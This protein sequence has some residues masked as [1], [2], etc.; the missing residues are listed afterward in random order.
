MTGSPVLGDAW[1]DVVHEWLFARAIPHYVR[2]GVDPN[3]LAYEEFNFDGTPK[4]STQRRVMV[5]FRQTY[6]LAHAALLGE[7]S[8]SIPLGLFSRM[9][10]S[11][12]H[13]DGGWVHCLDAEGHV[14]DTTREAYDQAFAM[15]A[16]AWIYELTGSAEVLEWAK[17]SVEFLQTKMAGPEGGYIEAVP[18]RCPRRQNPHMHLFE[19]FLALFEASRDEFF[20]EQAEAVRRLLER[21]FIATNG[22][23]REYFGPELEELTGDV[24]RAVEPGHHFE[25]VWLLHEHARLRG[26]EV[27][28]VESRLFEF[29][30]RHGVDCEGL[31]IE[32]IDVSGQPR[33]SSRKLWA[34]SEQLKA[35]TVRS[36]RPNL[37]GP[38]LNLESVLHGIFRC[39]PSGESAPVWYERVD[40]KGDART[41]R[42]PASTLYHLTLA[43]TEYLRSKH[44]VERCIGRRSSRS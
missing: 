10:S 34:L 41:S 11:A 6:V 17:R 35:A 42:M 13:R 25:W 36:E 8:P 22:A 7:C 28:G 23:L 39:F 43:F 15:L 18:A 3:G 30:M 24:G 38:G 14:V 31:A 26:S 40:A 2:H 27:A 1:V 21:Y 29:A 4:P 33:D 16:C 32:Q 37:G 20:L 44:R 9:L 19:A 12:W 5:Q